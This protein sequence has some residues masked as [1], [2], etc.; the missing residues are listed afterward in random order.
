MNSDGEIEQISAFMRM[1][2]KSSTSP[3]L[4]DMPN[5]IWNM[6]AEKPE[7]SLQLFVDCLG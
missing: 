5:K 6:L 1:S 4:R 3:F 7:L 2:T